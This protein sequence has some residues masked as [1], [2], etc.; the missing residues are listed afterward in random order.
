MFGALKPLAGLAVDVFE[1]VFLD[2]GA[3]PA[4]DRLYREAQ[5]ASRWPHGEDW[6]DI[7]DAEY[8]REVLPDDDVLPSSEATY[9]DEIAGHLAAQNL[10]LEDIRS[11]LAGVGGTVPGCAPTPGTGSPGLM[12]AAAHGLRSWIKGDDCHAPTYW[13]LIVDSLTRTAD[14]LRRAK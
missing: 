8:A 5:A 4:V 3:I 10:V 2:G 1:A 12:G 6:D 7:P 13:Q 11:L 14:D 9:L